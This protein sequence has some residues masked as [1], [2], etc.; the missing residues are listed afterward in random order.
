MFNRAWV[1]FKILLS[2]GLVAA[3]I[4]LLVAAP[5][6]VMEPLFI[7]ISSML[8]F[9]AAVLWL[10][11]STPN[12]A[13][14]LAG[15]VFSIWIGLLAARSALGYVEF[16]RPCTGR[17]RIFCEIEN[18][19]FQVGG[20]YLAAAPF[21]LLALVI[22]RLSVRTVCRTLGSHRLTIDE[23]WRSGR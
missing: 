23:G 6:A 8:L 17:G 21:G 19:L 2:L 15:I 13:V 12:R 10:D 14:G 9:F 4:V 18:L 16:P 5:N 11:F 1:A 20:E 22:L 7:G 3:P